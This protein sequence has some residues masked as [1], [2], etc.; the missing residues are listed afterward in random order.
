MIPETLCCCGAVQNK[1]AGLKA[2]MSANL[3]LSVLLVFSGMTAAA[4]VKKSIVKFPTDERAKT[5]AER[6]KILLDASP[7]LKLIDQAGRESP[8]SF[9]W[10]LNTDTLLKAKDLF[11][12]VIEFENGV[13]I[14]KAMAADTV[15]LSK[16]DKASEDVRRN[17]YS[18]SVSL[19]SY[20]ISQ[21]KGKPILVFERATAPN[22]LY[23]KVFLDK[24]AKKILKLQSLSTGRFY[25]PVPFEGGTISL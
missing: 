24:T 5:P 1:N 8:L 9:A 16:S 25:L 4:Q 14:R 19:D 11:R 13:S 17:F 2:F 23:F 15:R 18:Y 21:Q 12:E 22:K 20:A 3:I 10:Q 6:R 7:I